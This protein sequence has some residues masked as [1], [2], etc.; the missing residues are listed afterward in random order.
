[1]AH[2][3]QHGH[4]ERYEELRLGLRQLATEVPAAMAGFGRLHRDAMVDGA[5]PRA[6]KELIALGIGICTPCD[7]CVTFHVHD[8]LLAGA[9]RAEVLEAIGVA[10]MMGG[11]PASIYATIALDALDEFE[12]AASRTIGATPS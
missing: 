3:A 5:L 9:T 2:A 10:V 4:V 11:G 1:M 8:A 12:A 6:T 7:G